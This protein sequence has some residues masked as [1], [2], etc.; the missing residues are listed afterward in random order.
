[1]V[2]FSVL[3]LLKSLSSQESDSC[4]WLS[5][6]FRKCNVDWLNFCPWDF[7]SKRL[8]RKKTASFAGEEQM[9]IRRTRE[10]WGVKTAVTPPWLRPTIVFPSDATPFGSHSHHSI[11]SSLPSLCPTL[12]HL[13]H[14][15]SVLWSIWSHPH[16]I[17]SK[18]SQS[19]FPRVQPFLSFLK[20]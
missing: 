10:V 19:I 3:Y 12:L 15:I 17:S 1:M 9:C 16:F 11:Q 7:F 4:P 5:T 18:I 13:S 6:R 8:K 14:F 20:L 2:S